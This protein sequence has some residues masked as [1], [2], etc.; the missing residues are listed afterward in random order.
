MYS[1]KGTA[2]LKVFFPLLCVVSDHQSALFIPEKGIVPRT[3]DSLY[4]RGAERRRGKL[5]PASRIQQIASHRRG[6]IAHHI[7][8]TAGI[9]AGVG[10]IN[11]IPQDQGVRSLIVDGSAGVF[12]ELFSLPNCSIL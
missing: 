5:G 3:L 1:V 12:P 9:S 10:K 7:I 2:P 8:I 11:R 4:G 6:E